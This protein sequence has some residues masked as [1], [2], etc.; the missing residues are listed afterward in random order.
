ML[1]SCRR[2]WLEFFFKNQ[3]STSLIKMRVN[4]NNVQGMNDASKFHDVLREA[5]KYDI[6]FLQET[7]SEKLSLHFLNSDHTMQF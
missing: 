3:Q 4:S 6:A 5:R 7:N 1:Y 2:R